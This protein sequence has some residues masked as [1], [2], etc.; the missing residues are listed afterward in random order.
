[1]LL[2]VPI[3]VDVIKHPDQWRSREERFHVAPNSRSQYIKIS[4]T[5]RQEFKAAEN[6]K[7]NEQTS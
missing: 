3:T 6:S 4:E 5:S 2:P 7:L 1:M